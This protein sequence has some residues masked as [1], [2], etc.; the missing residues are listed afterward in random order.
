MGVRMG[1][2]QNSSFDGFELIQ[3]EQK[4]SELDAAKIAAKNQ[5]DALATGDA[6]FFYSEESVAAAKAA[7]EGIKFVQDNGDDGIMS[8][9]EW[10]KSIQ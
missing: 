8:L 6:L 5:L 2:N 1:W 4:T 7:A 10:H 3:V 9:Q